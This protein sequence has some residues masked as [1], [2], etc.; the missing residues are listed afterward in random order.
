[1]NKRVIWTEEENAFLKKY[2]PAK[3]SKFVAEALGKTQAAVRGHAVNLSVKGA[4]NQ[5]RRNYT[6]DEIIFIKKNYPN[7]GSRYVGQKLGRTPSSIVTKARK[8]RI[9]RKSL[10]LWSKQD[11]EYIIKYYKKKPASIIANHLGRTTKAIII[12]AIR[13]G[14]QKHETRKWTKEEEL[15]LI[16]NYRRMSYK[17]IGKHLNRSEQSVMRKLQN[18]FKLKKYNSRKWTAKEKRLLGRIYGKVP[19]IELAE[20]LNRS[21]PAISARAKVQ[22]KTSKRPPLFSDKEKQFIRKNY[23]KMT[24]GQIGKK[25]HRPAASIH[26]VASKLGL[27]GNPE[28]RRLNKGT[29]LGVPKIPYTKKEKEYISKNYLKKT[30]RQLSL[31]LNRPVYC[32][33]GIAARLGLTGNPEKNIIWRTRKGK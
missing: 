1:M 20:R 30:N 32:I 11:D 33:Q 17:Q 21:I 27:T 28:K 23:L 3:G 5:P 7:K 26:R 25:L 12:R 16:A 4:W 22:N 31:A 13:L 10:L 9:D 6:A 29:S 15:F 18:S 19:V 14:I 24:N 2:Y 8:L